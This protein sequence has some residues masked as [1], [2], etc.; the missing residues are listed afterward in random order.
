M[1]LTTCVQTHGV[2]ETLRFLA[3]LCENNAVSET[4]TRGASAESKYAARYSE[5]MGKLLR[6]FALRVQEIER[7]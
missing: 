1:D 2:A 3:T 5:R 7:R 4:C 6:G